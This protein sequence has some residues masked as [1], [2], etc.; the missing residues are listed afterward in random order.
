MCLG[1]GGMMQPPK[2]PAPPP[3]QPG[4]PSPDDSVNN[5]PVPN[6]NEREPLQGGSHHD[7]WK[8]KNKNKPTY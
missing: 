7:E 5:K 3:Q 6:Q 4:Q 8:N 1:G 2:R